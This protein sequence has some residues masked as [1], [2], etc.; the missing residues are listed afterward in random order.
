MG[1]QEEKLQ[2]RAEVQEETRTSRRTFLR[3]GGIAGVFGVA[4]IGSLLT[5][6]TSS[7]AAASGFAH[8]DHDG[9]ADDLKK[10]D[11]DTDRRGNC[12][13]SGSHHV[14]EHHRECS[15]FQAPGIG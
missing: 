10:G 8:D 14:H 9:D 2:V 4:G 1:T 3:Q 12:R 6:G 15:V 11:R 5:L 13:G 7:G